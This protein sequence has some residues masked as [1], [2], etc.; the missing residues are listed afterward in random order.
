V[1]PQGGAWHCNRRKLCS[2]FSEHNLGD[3]A[4][5]PFPVSGGGCAHLGP[6]AKAINCLSLCLCPALIG[7]NL[8]PTVYVQRAAVKGLSCS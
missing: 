5:L 7:F 8:L 4:V 1:A 3:A 2:C 6:R